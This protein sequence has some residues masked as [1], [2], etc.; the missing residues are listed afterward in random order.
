MANVT[1]LVTAEV[2]EA[3]LNDLITEG[4]TLREKLSSLDLPTAWN[5]WQNWNEK[6]KNALE[7]MYKKNGRFLPQSP[8]EQFTASL[9][10]IL[11]SARLSG[12]K[13]LNDTDQEELRASLPDELSER[14]RRLESFR[15][16]LSDYALNYQLKEENTELEQNQDSI[17]IVH[18]RSDIHRWEV[19]DFINSCT[20]LEPI[21]LS[22]QPN[23]GLDLLGKFV[24]NARKTRFAVVI[25][26]GDDEGRL[27]G[28]KELKS[29]ARQNV[30]FEL[31]YFVG[32]LGRDK[33]AV[34]YE[35]NTELPSDFDGVVYIPLS[36][37]WKIQLGRELNNAGIQV[38][39]NKSL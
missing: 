36:Q 39:L 9:N 5:E 15:N 8:S 18:G 38:D 24:E 16:Q 7:N 26:T 30:I 4:Y 1:L 33:V 22:D 23:K 13:K 34:L 3:R 35:D 37:S 2:A 31:G 6:T 25:V 32:L 14:I 12:I 28:D 27:K 17:F 29:R 20:N 19:K 21:I 10:K 11:L